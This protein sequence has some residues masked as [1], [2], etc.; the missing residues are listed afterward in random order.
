MLR[1]RLRLFALDRIG[2]SELI[3]RAKSRWIEGDRAEAAAV[4]LAACCRCRCS[5]A[6]DGEGF[7]IN[8]AWTG[9]LWQLGGSCV[10]WGPAEGVAASVALDDDLE[11]KS[12]TTAQENL[13]YVESLHV[14]ICLCGKSMFLFERNVVF[15]QCKVCKHCAT[16]PNAINYIMSAQFKKKKIF[17]YIYYIGRH[18]FQRKELVGRTCIARQLFLI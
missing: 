2:N 17:I 6:C 8:P 5:A 16:F 11:W 10:C 7:E 15:L 9:A 3:S 13:Y 4:A 12:S 14:G 18:V 1:L